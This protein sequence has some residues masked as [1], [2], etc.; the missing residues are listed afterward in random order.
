[1]IDHIPELV[2]A[3]ID[4]LKI[5]GRMKTQL[6]AATTARTY[7][8]AIDDYFSDPL[9]YEQ[10]L[11]LYR[12]EIAKCTYREFCTGFYF[13]RPGKEAQIY[14]ASTYVKDY[15]FFGS[16]ESVDAEGYAHFVQKNKFSVGDRIEILKSDMTD[17]PVEVLSIRDEL[18]G[19]EMMSCP[20]ASQ[21]IKVRLSEAPAV[22]DILGG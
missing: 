16:V 10:N 4:S 19:E 7:R 2:E 6:Y 17:V 9:L 11:P 5:E 3:G 12:K 15:T 14:D 18:T 1:M 20:H 8:R 13:G 22:L 21:R